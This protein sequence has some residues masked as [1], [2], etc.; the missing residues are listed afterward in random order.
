MD[1]YVFCLSCY[2]ESNIFFFLHIIWRQSITI[3]QDR[4]L[5]S[6][7]FSP[8]SGAIPVKFTSEICGILLFQYL[9]QTVPGMDWNW[10]ALEC[11]DWNEHWKLSNRANFAFKDKNSNKIRKTNRDGV[12]MLLGYFALPNMVNNANEARKSGKM[13]TKRGHMTNYQK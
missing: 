3:I 1:G 8:D 10:M 4:S 7:I 9:H 13:E 5:Q 11:S 6:S 12:V 2:L